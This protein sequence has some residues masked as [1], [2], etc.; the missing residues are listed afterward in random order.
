M[1]TIYILGDGDGVFTPK[2]TA[3]ATIEA[4]GAGNSS[5]QGAYYAKL[6]GVSLTAGTP[7]PFNLGAAGGDTWWGATTV[8]S[9]TL[10]APGGGSATSPVGTVSHAGGSIG[11][12]TGGGAGGAGGPSGVGGNGG[13]G[14]NGSTTG[15][16]GGGDGLSGGVGNEGLIILTNVTATLPFLTGTLI[17]TFGMTIN[18]PVEAGLSRQHRGRAQRRRDHR[19]SVPVTPRG[20]R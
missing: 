19:L 20:L 12:N 13:G 1:T 4:W 15:G 8:G 5:G 14:G 17:I 6:T 18:G 10:V 11:A 9:A 2:S 3:T 7:V 16:G